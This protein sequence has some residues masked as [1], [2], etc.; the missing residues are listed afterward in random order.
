MDL[1][2]QRPKADFRQISEDLG[3]AIELDPFDAVCY[4]RRGIISVILA[5]RQTEESLRSAL[6]QEGLRDLKRA[7]E[8]EPGP[9]LAS[10]AD[11]WI[12]QA[13]K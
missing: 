3:K 11:P 10:Q 2:F 9:G 1:E 8:L 13:E 12:K 5:S 6:H 4:M 7:V